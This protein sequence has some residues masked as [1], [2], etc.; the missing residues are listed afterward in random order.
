MSSLY[1]YGV[2]KNAT[3]VPVRL[4]DCAGS[5]SVIGVVAALD[6]ILSPANPNPKTQAVLNLSIGGNVSTAFN[7]AIERVSNS[8]IAVVVA[9]G[10][11]RVDACTKSPASAP[12]AIAVGATNEIDVR[13]SFTNFGPCVDINAP[14]TEITAGWISSNS[15]T[16]KNPR[17]FNGIATCGRCCGCL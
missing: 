1:L 17:Y 2:A 13:A 16:K 5:G 4:L 15:S 10:N 7:D 6:W 9:A 3:I 14:G 8:G 12:S 11:D